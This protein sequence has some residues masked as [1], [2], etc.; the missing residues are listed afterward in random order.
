MTE[1]VRNTKTELNNSCDYFK[2]L[3]P[4]D[5]VNKRWSNKNQMQRGCNLKK[6][7][8]KTTYTFSVLL[9]IVFTDN[10]NKGVG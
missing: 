3:Q 2:L 4:K 10:G 9:F 7:F 6:R 8:L 1:S 5:E